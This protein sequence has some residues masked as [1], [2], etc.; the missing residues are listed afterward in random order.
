[1]GRWRISLAIGEMHHG[2]MKISLPIGKC[3]RGSWDDRESC[4]PLGKCIMGHWTLSLAIRKM[5][6]GMMSIL[7]PIGETHHE[8]MENLVT[9]WGNASWDGGE[10]CY[11]SGKCI[12]GS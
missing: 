8:M 3:I 6:H 1:M 11:P 2:M 4:R 5:H 12:M 7:L 9:H 10:C